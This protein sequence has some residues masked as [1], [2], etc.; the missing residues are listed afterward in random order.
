MPPIWIST[1]SF[2]INTFAKFKTGI[3]TY[4]ILYA[5]GKS[6]TI[7]GVL[8]CRRIAKDEIGEGIEYDID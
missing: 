1:A 3:A 5:D 6:S 8:M 4:Y 7:I 2:P